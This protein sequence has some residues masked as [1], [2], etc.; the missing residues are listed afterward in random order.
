MGI[1]IRDSGS[2]IFLTLDPRQKHPVS[3]QHCMNL[4]VIFGTYVRVTAELQ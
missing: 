4:T 2:G 3:A 1:R